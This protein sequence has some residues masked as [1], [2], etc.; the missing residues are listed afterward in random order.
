[1]NLLKKILLMPLILAALPASAVT[2]STPVAEEDYQN[3]VVHF[4]ALGS[5]GVA[6]KTCT[7]MLLG[8]DLLLTAGHCID[9]DEAQLEIFQGTDRWAPTSSFEV[10]GYAY[11][12][13]RSYHANLAWQFH[14]KHLFETWIEPATPEAFEG[15]VGDRYSA[16]WWLDRVDAS[17]AYITGMSDEDKEN[18]FLQS[19]NQNDFAIL[20]LDSSV[21]HHSGPILAP[22]INMGTGEPNITENDE[23]VF[24][25][26]GSDDRDTGLSPE[27]LKEGTFR[28]YRPYIQSQALVGNGFPASGEDRLAMCEPGATECYFREQS[29]IDLVGID[30]G[31]GYPASYFGDSGGPVMHGDYYFGSMYGGDKV[32]INGKYLSLFS[33]ITYLMDWLSGVI[34]KV[35][36]PSDIGVTISE[37]DALSH[38]IKIPLQNFTNDPIVVGAASVQGSEFELLSDCQGLLDSTEGCMIK[39]LFNGDQNAI[40]SEVFSTID[41]GLSGVGSLPMS[42]RFITEESV[43]PPEYPEYPGISCDD[44]PGYPGCYDECDIDA[45]APGCPPVECSVDPYQEKCVDNCEVWPESKACTE[46]KTTSPDADNTGGD[47]GGSSSIPFLILCMGVLLRRRLH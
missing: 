34:M 36:Y 42:V 13:Y 28:M 22:L 43:E 3:H 18:G 24:R 38:E 16:L 10:T 33:D 14:V 6:K 21:P 7:G 15:G 32:A 2:F 31:L 12:S 9:G 11:K 4:L 44:D 23:F 41:L 45:Y 47:S 20:V 39:V 35:V 27:T 40:D 25:G 26:Y 30:T 46:D 8:G 29:L 1:M 5:E 17:I 19:H 37:G